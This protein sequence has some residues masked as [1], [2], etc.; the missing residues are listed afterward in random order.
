MAATDQNEAPKLPPGVQA[1][2]SEKGCPTWAGSSGKC[3]QKPRG[4]SHAPAPTF[5]PPPTLR[6]SF[7]TSA[8]S[9]RGCV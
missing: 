4:L 7:L 3:P 2:P 6:P 8:H 9:V 1:R 5:S